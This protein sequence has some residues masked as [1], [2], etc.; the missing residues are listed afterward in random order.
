[1]LVDAATD[2]NFQTKGD[3]LRQLLKASVLINSQRHETELACYTCACIQ[4]RLS[5]DTTI[6]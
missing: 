4:L 5:K 3:E 6:A 2:I 1:M